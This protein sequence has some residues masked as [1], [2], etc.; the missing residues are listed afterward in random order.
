MTTRGTF[1]KDYLT[2]LQTHIHF[3]FINT[4]SQCHNRSLS[5]LEWTIVLHLFELDE[6]V[7]RSKSKNYGQTRGMNQPP[8][9]F[10]RKCFRKR[11]RERNSLNSTLQYTLKTLSCKG[12]SLLAE[13]VTMLRRGFNY[14][15]SSI[16]HF[17]LF[18][19]W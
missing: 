18:Q 5:T 4:G 15:A 11:E 9:T 2:T 13:S 16:V 19:L 12:K 17:G 8:V 14:Y 7:S 10:L 1:K 6:Q 3:S